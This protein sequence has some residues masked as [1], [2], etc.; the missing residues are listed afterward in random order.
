MIE[1]FAVSA[2]C[3]ISTMFLLVTLLEGWAS[4]GGWSL[5]RVAGLAAG[6]LWPLLITGFLLH[7]LFSPR[8]MP[9]LARCS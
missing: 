6:A 3:A 1:S 5:M 7:N 2:Y 9:V 8:R 4:R